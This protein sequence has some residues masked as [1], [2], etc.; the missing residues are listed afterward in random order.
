MRWLAVGL[1]AG[2]GAWTRCPSGASVPPESS[3]LLPAGPEE[4]PG[5][6]HVKR[7]KGLM[8]PSDLFCIIVNAFSISEKAK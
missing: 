6:N 7:I 2:A 5:N 1:P 8:I 3:V 4:P